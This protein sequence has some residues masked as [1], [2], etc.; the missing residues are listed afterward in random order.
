M[1]TLSKSCRH[2][3][4]VNSLLGVFLRPCRAAVLAIEQMLSQIDPNWRTNP[5]FKAVTDALNAVLKIAADLCPSKTRAHALVTI[6]GSFNCLNAS[7][8]IELK[9]SIAAIQVVLETTYIALEVAAKLETD[10][11][12]KQN[13]YI[14]ANAVNII[15]HVLVVSF[16]MYFSCWSLLPVGRWAV[17]GWHWCGNFA[18]RAFFSL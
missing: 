4:H 9:K 12:T 2:K 6:G 5:I 15:N 14:V 1:T 16:F 7:Q 17:S 13:L 11:K 3:S 18:V 10:N 8:V